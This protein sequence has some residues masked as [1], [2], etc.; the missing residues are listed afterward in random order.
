MDS[1]SLCM[2]VLGAMV[3]GT[4]G[5][6]TNEPKKRT[7]QRVERI[8]KTADRW[9]QREREGPARIKQTALRFDAQFKKDLRTSRENRERLENRLREDYR[10]WR[11]SR[12]RHRR[13]VESRLEGDLD[14]AARTAERIFY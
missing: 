6:R 11:D 1:H 14:R 9:V 10:W 8:K 2:L 5:C 7:R 4:P 3:L 13:I 12:S